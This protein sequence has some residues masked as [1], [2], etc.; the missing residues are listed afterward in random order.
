[1]AAASHICEC[2]VLVC[3]HSFF[4]LEWPCYSSVE[5]AYQ[6]L[7]YAITHCVAIDAD[8]TEAAR[9]SGRLTGVVDSDEED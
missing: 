2:C 1:M 9:A 6:R 5:V 7:L 8:S 3:L 4:S